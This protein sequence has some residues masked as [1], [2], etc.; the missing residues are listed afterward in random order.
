LRNGSL[1]EQ[2]FRVVCRVLVEFGFLHPSL[3]KRRRIPLSTTQAAMAIRRINSAIEHS[4]NR[5]FWSAERFWKNITFVSEK[6]CRDRRT[7]R[8]VFD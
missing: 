2:A 8:F 6:L 3:S 5:M 7:D 4:T 1:A